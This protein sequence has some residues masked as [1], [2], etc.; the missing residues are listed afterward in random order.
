MRD[1]LSL[2]VVLWT[3]LA[4]L[5]APESLAAQDRGPSPELMLFEEIPMVVTATRTARSA[6]DVPSAVTVITSADIKAAGATT[7]LELLETVPGLDLM[8]ISKSD[9]QAASRGLV[10]PSTTS[11]LTMV[12]GRSVYADFFGITTWENIN[13]TLQDID[14]IEIVRGPGSALYGANAFAGTINIVTKRA[15]DLP[16]AY[17]RTGY[18]PDR[19]L[20]TAT[21]SAATSRLAIKGSAQYDSR[22]DFRN[23][24]NPA[25]NTARTR[26]TN[27]LRAKLVNATLEYTTRG[28]SE[29]RL[30]GGR[31][32]GKLD[33]LTG[34]GT[35]DSDGAANHAQLNFDSGPWS[36]QTF[37]SSTDLDLATVVM[38]I[39][40]TVSVADVRSS[41]FDAE[42]QR[43]LRWGRH[44]LLG[45]LNVRRISTTSG[46]ILG[47]KEEESL[48]A[49][50]FQDVVGVSD[51][52]TGFL[53]LRVDRHPLTGSHVSPRAALVYQIGETGRLRL[54]YSRSYKNPT[55]IFT[56]SS[57]AASPA[58]FVQG[59]EDLDPVWLTAYEA[60]GELE[61]IHGLRLQGDLFLNMIVDHQAFGIVAPGF[62]V[63]TGFFNTGRTKIWGGEFAFEWRGKRWLRAFGNYSYQNAMGDLESATPGHKA[64]LGLRGN[65]PLRLRYALTSNFTSRTEFEGG[66]LTVLGL[67]TTDIP[68][69]LTVDAF[70]GLEVRDGV[71]LGFHARNIFHQVRQQF[72]IGDEIGSELF[73]TITVEF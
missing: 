57:F 39:V 43:T 22:D 17:V 44:E 48:Y 69:R 18:G 42:L 9:F 12:D 26:H 4:L 13:V 68:S 55:A 51:D 34:I 31:T 41:V 35:F 6:R 27:G 37:Y 53:S 56:Y 11:L 47:D 2:A 67:P 30:S 21:G 52:L 3:T 7:I 15:R 24:A 23:V 19:S 8:Q 33:T 50:F 62:P 60:G 59:N 45:G 38:P 65:L 70:L 63:T 28:G 10:A 16:T 40:P 66:A 25:P 73:A 72:P 5:G 32:D 54:S 49:G 1:R 29:W 14:R 36:V 58:I 20:V 64:T 46:D 71:E 61:P